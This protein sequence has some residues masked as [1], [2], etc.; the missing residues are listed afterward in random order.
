MKRFAILFMVLLIVITLS[1]CSKNDAINPATSQDVSS[2][3]INPE[4]QTNS[5]EASSSQIS[6]EPQ[7]SSQESGTKALVFDMN[8]ADPMNGAPVYE[9]G[10][11]NVFAVFKESSEEYVG[12]VEITQKVL[13]AYDKTIVNYQP[14]GYLINS[15]KSIISSQPA[16]EI[17]VEAKNALDKLA[18]NDKGQFFYGMLPTA[19][20]SEMHF[21]DKTNYFSIPFDYTIISSSTFD[22]PYLLSVEDDNAKLFLYFDE[23]ISIQVEGEMKDYSA[24]KPI[25]ANTDA[26]FL[27]INE[28]GFSPETNTLRD[29][30]QLLFLGK[31][32]GGTFNGHMYLS[33]TEQKL[34]LMFASFTGKGNQY[35]CEIE[36]NFQPFDKETYRNAGGQMSDLH[37]EKLSHMAVADCE[38]N[39]VLFTVAGDTVF[40]EMPNEFQGIIE[41]KFIDEDGEIERIFKESLELFSVEFAYAKSGGS[42]GVDGQCL[43]LPQGFIPMTSPIYSMEQNLIISMMFNYLED[44]LF[45]D[46]IGPIYI[47]S[48]DGMRDFIVNEE[49]YIGSNTMEIV[50]SYGDKT[51]CIELAED[52]EG[53]F[54]DVIVFGQY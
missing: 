29:N 7:S 12:E 6:E 44:N 52:D 23:V 8:I 33:Q 19:T 5:E 26:A 38:G 13:Q 40:V 1:A 46:T 42:M 15:F 43:W 4:I 21:D 54:V 28:K 22:I 39:N 20:R 2:E 41:G 30:W 14:D 17:P 27:Y 34:D 3:V 53:T 11:Y 9:Q 49:L 16:K 37:T 48:F 35:D 31:N 45:L 47:K 10:V 18:A 50:F 25:A 24:D 36:L 51:I 32:E